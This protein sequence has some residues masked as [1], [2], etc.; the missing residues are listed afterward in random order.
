M[1]MVICKGTGYHACAIERSLA[2]TPLGEHTLTR[3]IIILISRAMSVGAHSTSHHILPLP[4]TPY[5]L[6]QRYLRNTA[7]L[8]HIKHTGDSRC[9]TMS[10]SVHVNDAHATRPLSGNPKRK[11]HLVPRRIRRWNGGIRG[12]RVMSLGCVES[13]GRVCTRGTKGARGV[14]MGCTVAD[15]VHKTYVGHRVAGVYAAH[16]FQSP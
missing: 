16:P 15:V 1:S 8:D 9:P 13:A 2:Y 7:I 11:F 6:M 3:S 5:L 12:V 4:H 10:H 14:C